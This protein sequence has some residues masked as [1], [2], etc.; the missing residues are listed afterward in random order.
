[1]IRLYFH[2]TPNPAKIG[3]FPEETGLP[4]KTIAVD[5]SQDEQRHPGDRR[6]TQGP[7]MGRQGDVRPGLGS[8]YVT[9]V[10]RA[11]EVARLNRVGR[12]L[13]TIPQG[14]M[15]VRAAAPLR[16]TPNCAARSSIS[17]ATTSQSC[18]ALK[19]RF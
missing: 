9:D 10:I 1:M 12:G 15:P 13:S 6:R 3:P 2:P 16:H 8:S 18:S 4:C 19:S 7:D 14:F 11:G 5:T 17:F